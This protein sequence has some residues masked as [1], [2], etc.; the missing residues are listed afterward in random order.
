MK[1]ENVILSRREF[2]KAAA[3]SSVTCGLMLGGA[4]VAPAKCL[5]GSSSPAF[6]RLRCMGAMLRMGHCAPTVMHTLIETGRKDADYTRLIT[7]SA[8]MPGGIGNM[9]CECGG[10]TSALMHLGLTP[11][12]DEKVQNI[13]RLIHVGR[14]YMREFQSMHSS[15]RCDKINTPESGMSACLEAV[16]SAKRLVFGA[17]RNADT[18][19]LSEDLSR[20]YERVLTVFEDTSFHCAHSVLSGVSDLV[21]YDMTLIAA[22][23]GFVG[24]TVFSGLTC[25]AFTA[26][27]VAIGAA[28]GEIEDSVPRVLRMMWLM[29]NGKDA[30][31]DDV[32]A[33]NR[34][35]NIGTK[36]GEWFAGRFGSTQCREIIGA[37]MST[38]AG[39]QSYRGDDAVDRCRKI[40]DETAGKV[41]ELIVGAR[42]G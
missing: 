12:M 14:S 31:A 22:A 28:V 42:A 35:M 4:A 11:G 16:C 7:L 9:G 29:K 33:F 41:R 3:T 36:L 32:N 40:A 20:E 8:G 1:I 30:L 17:K 15:L 26:G 10:V 18:T 6:S 37:D 21:D 34:P 5:G 23:R 27:V 38:T 19:L 13:P 24:G 2:H 25:G 39:V